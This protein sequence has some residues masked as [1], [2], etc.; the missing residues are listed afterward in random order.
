MN[1]RGIWGDESG[2][3]AQDQWVIVWQ[4]N[5]VGLEFYCTCQVKDL[6][7]LEPEECVLEMME[8]QP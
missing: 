8:V 7:D 2:Q 3:L 4:V 1:I 6:G 5:L